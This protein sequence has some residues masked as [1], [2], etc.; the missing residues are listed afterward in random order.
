MI[1]TKAREPGW[2]FALCFYCGHDLR[3]PFIE[4]RGHDQERHDRWQ[5]LQLHEE[6][7]FRLA[8][9]LEEEVKACREAAVMH[10]VERQLE[11][12]FR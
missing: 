9:L 2:D 11:E 7:A 6:C 5:A 8:V 10:W 4:W 12:K 3:T 1:I